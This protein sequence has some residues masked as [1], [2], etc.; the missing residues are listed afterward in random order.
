MTSISLEGAVEARRSSS[1]SDIDETWDESE[2]QRSRRKSMLKMNLARLGIL[3]VFFGA[4]ELIA[5]RW[6]DPFWIS[7]PSDIASVLYDWIFSGYIWPHFASTM[8]AMVLGFVSGGIFGAALGLVLGRSPRLSALLEP[9]ITA[10]Y[11]IPRITLAPLFILW[12]GLGLQSKVALSATIVSLL[13]FESTFAGVKT[14]EKDLI[15]VVRVMGANRWFVTTKVIIPGALPWTFVG[16]RLSVPYA[17]AGA[18]VAEFV[19]SSQGLGWVIQNASGVFDTAGVFAGLTIL[20]ATG[21]LLNRLVAIAEK[22]SGRWR[23]PS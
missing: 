1:A 20:G 6:V 11:S 9:F 12:L 7:R 3:A 18:V 23:M 14:A 16:L 10:L 15:D 2:L 5:G 22:H 8:L 21:F 4:W 13:T 19:A 17:L